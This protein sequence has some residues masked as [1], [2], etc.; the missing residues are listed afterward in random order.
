VPAKF[1][2]EARKQMAAA[3]NA[4]TRLGTPFDELVRSS[5]LPP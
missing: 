2:G 4:T 3:Q 1:R 5:A